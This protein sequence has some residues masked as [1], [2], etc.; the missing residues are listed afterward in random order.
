MPMLGGPRGVHR[1]RVVNDLHTRQRTCF[2]AGERRVCRLLVRE[3]ERAGDARVGCGF[4]TWSRCQLAMTTALVRSISGRRVESR[5]SAC[6]AFS[7][8]DA[9][10]GFGSDGAIL[11]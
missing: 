5:S 4:I 9:L 6:R 8:L 7:L 10:R 11:I 3:S 1:T 2:V